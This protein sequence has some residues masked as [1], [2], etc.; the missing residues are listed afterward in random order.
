M[1]ILHLGSIGQLSNIVTKNKYELDENPFK[2]EEQRI[3]LR[4]RYEAYIK[5][6]LKY[7]MIIWC[8]S[9]LNQS[10][11]LIWIR[12]VLNVRIAYPNKIKLHIHIPHEHYARSGWR[13]GIDTTLWCEYLDEA[14]K[15]TEYTDNL[16]L[17]HGDINKKRKEHIKKIEQI[18]EEIHKGVIDCSSEIIATY[19]HNPT[20]RKTGSL[21][22]ALEYA[23]QK[24]KTIKSFIPRKM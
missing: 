13:R 9:G 5:T 1:N 6:K 17:E 11:D 21:R 4:K 10:T 3:K 8:H 16:E 15:I 24:N 2:K 18:N 12:A 19:D 14:N 7:H 20:T 23:V 22:N